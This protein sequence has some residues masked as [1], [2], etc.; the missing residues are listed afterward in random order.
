MKMKLK[1]L[2]VAASIAFIGGCAQTPQQQ[3]STEAKPASSGA[4]HGKYTPYTKIVD[5]AYVKPHATPPIDRNKNAIVI[6]SR[7]AKPRYDPGHLPGAISIEEPLFD[8]Q[9][10]RLPA[11]KAKEIIFYCQGPA[12][13]LSH[14]SAYK[15][16]KLGYTN[17]KVYQGGE[18]DWKAKGEFL[19][20]STAFINKTLADKADIVLIDARPER[21]VEKGS[22]PGAINI[23]D[24]KFD[25]AKLPA[26]KDKPLI[27]FCGGPACDLSEKSAHKAKQLGHT[28]VRVYVDGYPG[29]AAANKTA[30]P[31]ATPAAAP[32]PAPAAAPAAAAPAATAPVAAGGAFKVVTT[33]DKEIISTP[34]FESVVREDPTKLTIIDVR[35][36]EQCKA[37]TWPGALCIPL[38]ELEGKLASLPQGKP[39]VFICATGAKSSMAHDL[40]LEK[41]MPGEAYI[42][43]AEIEMVGGKLQIKK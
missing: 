23:P 37:G 31:A 34:F 2:V 14:S 18:P 25:A 35:K 38:A 30:A 42:L 21:I 7:P 4:D 1:L 11:D 16:E 29:W 27:F 6:D 39:I 10:D 8:K 43:D 22:I 20:V 32:A 15:A 36:I 3:A 41:K 9:K 26:D 24:N 13:E 28:N 12:C 40:F 17:I 19:S 5:F 33:K